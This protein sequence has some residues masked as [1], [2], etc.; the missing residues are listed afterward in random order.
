MTSLANVSV[1]GFFSETDK[2][3]KKIHTTKVVSEVPLPAVFKS[4]IR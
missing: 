3:N 1:H 2:D 4:P